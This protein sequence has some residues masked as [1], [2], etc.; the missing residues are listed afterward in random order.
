[1]DPLG[2]LAIIEAPTASSGSLRIP[3]RVPGLPPASRAG[4]PGPSRPKLAPCG[5]SG[6]LGLLE[7]NPG[8]LQNHGLSNGVS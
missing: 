4:R 5:G 7:Q 6:L 8:V 2:I 3:A 1:M